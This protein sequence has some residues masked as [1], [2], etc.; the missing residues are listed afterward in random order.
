M[1]N[2]TLILLSTLI[3]FLVMA[4]SGLVMF[5][6]FQESS[7]NYFLGMKKA[8]WMNIHNISGIFAVVLIAYHVAMRWVWIEHVILRKK[9]MQLSKE[10]IGRRRN[11]TW[12]L[13]FFSLTFATGFLSW[14]MGGDCEYCL[15]IHDKLGVVL[16]LIF[17]VHFYKHRKSFSRKSK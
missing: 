4:I 2:K 6:I 13:L 9:K 1:A 8:G 5:F 16:F 15:E 10:M 12:F 14:I 7:L 17:L 3:A 11:N